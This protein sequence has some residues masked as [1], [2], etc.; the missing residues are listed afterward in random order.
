MFEGGDSCL[1]RRNH[2]KNAHQVSVVLF[3]ADRR[4]EDELRDRCRMLDCV[5]SREVCAKGVPNENHSFCMLLHGTCQVASFK[6]PPRSTAT[7]KHPPRHHFI[8]A[9]NECEMERD[10]VDGSETELAL[11]VRLCISPGSLRMGR[12]G[13]ISGAHTDAHCLLPVVDGS[14]KV[15][16]RLFQCTSTVLWPI[17]A[18]HPRQVKRN[19]PPVLCKI[20]ELTRPERQTHAEAVDHYDRRQVVC[21]GGTLHVDCVQLGPIPASHRYK[22]V[23]HRHD[24][25]PF[26]CAQSHCLH[27]LTHRSRNSNSTHNYDSNELMTLSFDLLASSC[28][29]R[30]TSIQRPRR[31]PERHVRNV[32]RNTLQIA[33]NSHLPAFFIWAFW[34]VFADSILF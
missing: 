12:R 27:C 30:T 6:T 26:S 9:V 31:T 3:E 13:V 34:R 20:V 10:K 7:W 25:V 1:H 21:P 24:V 23:C 19:H 28:P 32:H 8:S 33:T 16:L 17:R 18:S 29:S 5:D 14:D 2:G 22:A 11:R 15:I 4:G